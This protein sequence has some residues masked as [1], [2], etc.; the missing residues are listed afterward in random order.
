[1][2]DKLL[3]KDNLTFNNH[4]K[5]DNEEDEHYDDD[6]NKKRLK[7]KKRVKRPP[8]NM[9]TLN[10]SICETIKRDLLRIWN[11]LSVVIL[12]LTSK[13]KE[14]ELR[15]WDLWGPFLFCLLFGL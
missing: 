4:K 3:T 5:E 6:E 13:E 9:N 7:L 10:E 14:K 8:T 2:K 12:P 15:H 11:K 1:M